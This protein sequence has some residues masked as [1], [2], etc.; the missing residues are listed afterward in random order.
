MSHNTEN[1]FIYAKRLFQE[2]FFT[3]KVNLCIR[4]MIEVANKIELTLAGQPCPSSSPVPMAQRTSSA[5][6]DH[7]GGYKASLGVLLIHFRSFCPQNWVPF[8][9][10]LLA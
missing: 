4:L 9:E 3:M 5:I 1:I 6:I 7:S 10:A 2:E 8:F